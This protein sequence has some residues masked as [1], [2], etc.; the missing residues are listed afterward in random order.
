MK[1]THAGAWELL[2]HRGEGAFY[3]KM[4]AIWEKVKFWSGMGIECD[5]D[6]GDPKPGW[7]DKVRRKFNGLVFE[8][9]TSRDKSAEEALAFV[10]ERFPKLTDLFEEVEKAGEVG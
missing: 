1:T 6:T 4:I 8:T 3:D 5:A 7:Q 9:M 2:A 10:R